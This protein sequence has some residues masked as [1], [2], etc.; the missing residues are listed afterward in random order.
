M[1]KFKYHR[2]VIESPAEFLAVECHEPLYD[3]L[4]YALSEWAALQ[5]ETDSNET[6]LVPVALAKKLLAELT[7]EVAAPAQL[8]TEVENMEVA[9]RAEKREE[10]GPRATILIS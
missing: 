5:V 2:D 6:I 3:A 1:F 8:A 9:I 7:G 4:A 10:E